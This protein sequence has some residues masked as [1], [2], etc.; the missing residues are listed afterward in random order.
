MGSVYKGLRPFFTSKSFTLLHSLTPI[1]LVDPSV[2]SNPHHPLNQR[3]L[4]RIKAEETNEP[5]LI[6]T[7]LA[8]K[9]NVSKNSVV[10]NKAVRRVRE[11]VYEILRVKGYG[12]EGESLRVAEKY[13]GNG[14]ERLV[15]TL[16]FSVTMDSVVTAWSDLKGE[17]GVA[18]DKFIAISQKVNSKSTLRPRSGSERGPDPGRLRPE[19][20]GKQVRS[21]SNHG[22]SPGDKDERDT[23][24][25]HQH[26][27][28]PYIAGGNRA[29][30]LVNVLKSGQGLQQKAGSEINEYGGRP[31]ARMIAAKPYQNGFR[32]QGGEEHPPAA[33]LRSQ[34]SR[35]PNGNRSGDERSIGTKGEWN[36]TSQKGRWR[37]FDE[38]SRFI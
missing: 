12:R 24:V 29:K 4:E 19:L 16:S 15:G 31:E 8:T 9:K 17:I 33:E 7:A 13:A 21:G 36:N 10:R 6:I 2:V 28:G 32:R 23:R 27:Q 26:R 38:G 34:K 18:I 20:S 1:V 35:F 25:A 14:R 22:K 37:G 30:R 11:A 3:V 5:R